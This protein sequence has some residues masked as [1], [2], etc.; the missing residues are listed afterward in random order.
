[1]SMVT[2]MPVFFT[3]ESM[4]T[5]CSRVNGQP[6]TDSEGWLCGPMKLGNC[7]AIKGKS[8]WP[9]SARQLPIIA[10]SCRS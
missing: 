1:M 5:K 8:P 4:L 10:F 6:P 2:A 3:M 7:T 9:Q